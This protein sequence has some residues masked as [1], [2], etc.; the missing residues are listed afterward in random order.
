VVENLHHSIRPDHCATLAESVHMVD[1]ET[2]R[3]IACSLPESLDG[4]SATA[5][6]FYVRDKQF[7]WSYHER[8]HPKGPRQPRLDVLAV[9]CAP[10]EKE[11]L[12]ASDPGKFFTTDHYRGFP[13][14][15]V[16]LD[17]VDEHEIRSLLTAACRCQAPPALRRQQGKKS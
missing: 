8:V 6:R 17:C 12:L 11:Q 13:A 16:Y 2:V 10:A 9:R 4:S 3:R 1:L 14:V 5:L 7:A 15:L